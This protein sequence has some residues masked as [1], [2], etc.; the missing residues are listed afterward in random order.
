MNQANKNNKA[1]EEIDKQTP[2]GNWQYLTQF[3]IQW[4]VGH[5]TT[6]LAAKTVFQFN[7]IDSNPIGNHLSYSFCNLLGHYLPQIFFADKTTTFFQHH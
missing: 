7:S 5:P 4:V 6:V 2:D 1:K 3:Q